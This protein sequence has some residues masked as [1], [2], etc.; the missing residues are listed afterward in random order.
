MKGARGRGSKKNNK[1]PTEISCYTL[2]STN[3]HVLGTF[4]SAST[5]LSKLRKSYT[6]SGENACGDNG[7]F[8][9]RCTA[10]IDVPI[11]GGSFRRLEGL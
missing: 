3:V 10:S 5:H 6:Q 2:P 7:S 8:E 11:G 9:H 4:R 1:R